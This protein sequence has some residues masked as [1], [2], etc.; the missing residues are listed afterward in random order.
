MLR[1]R[2]YNVIDY[3]NVMFMLCYVMLSIISIFDC[4]YVV[5]CAYVYVYVMLYCVIDCVM[6]WC[7]ICLCYVVYCAYV[8]VLLWCVICLCLCD[9]VY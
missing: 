3:V 2:L 5:Y 4:V 8:Y 9:V 6:L 1:Y 7:V